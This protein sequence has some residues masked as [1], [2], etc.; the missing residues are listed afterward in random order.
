MKKAHS[1]DIKTMQFVVKA[2]IEDLDGIL[3]RYE[4]RGWLSKPMEAPE[5]YLEA[6]TMAICTHALLS[7]LNRSHRL[8]FIL[9]VVIGVDSREGG[10]ILNISPAAYRQ[11]LSRARR[12]MK[13]FLV[14]NCGLLDDANRC[15]CGCILSVYLQK[16]WIHPDKPLFAGKSNGKEAP[17]RLG[18]YLQEM[19]DLGRL[20]ALY[21]S[22]SPSSPDFVARVKTIY[23]ARQYRLFSNTENQGRPA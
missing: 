11:R 12:R 9:G 3:D 6:E 22:V 2:S 20:S 4:A 13:D 17:V 15:S 21:R 5:P 14:N 23:N 8:A 10:Q 19:D 16:G 1:D 18:A 7:A